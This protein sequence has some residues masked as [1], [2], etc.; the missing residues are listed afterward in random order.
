[1]IAQLYVR[2]I[3]AVA[4]TVPPLAS[5]V[6]KTAPVFFGARGMVSIVPLKSRVAS[7]AQA[8][9]ASAGAVTKASKRSSLRMCI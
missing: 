6:D 4:E 5:L 2:F 3:V 7:A 9:P 1:M 8:D